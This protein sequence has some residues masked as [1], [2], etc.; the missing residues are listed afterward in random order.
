MIEKVKI[1]AKDPISVAKQDPSYEGILSKATKIE[2]EMKYK[3]ANCLTRYC[4]A[5]SR[6]DEHVYE[7]Q[8]IENAI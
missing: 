6:K 2:V 5:N 7:T 8:M 3:K 4:C 1:L